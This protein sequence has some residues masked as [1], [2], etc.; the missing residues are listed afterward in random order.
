MQRYNEAIIQYTKAVSID[1][2]YADAYLNRSIAAAKLHRYTMAENDLIKM[3][4]IDIFRNDY[5]STYNQIR[6]IL[7]ERED[8]ASIEFKNTVEKLAEQ[9]K[10]PREE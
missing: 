5:L 10:K 7:E 8:E 3:F 4:S 6:D 1:S 9:I 2:E